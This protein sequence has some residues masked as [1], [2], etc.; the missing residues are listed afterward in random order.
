MLFRSVV[1]AGVATIE[2]QTDPWLRE[3]NGMLET[4]RSR[5]PGLSDDLAPVRDL[6]GRPRSYE[7]GIGWAYDAFSPIYSRRHNPNAIDQEILRHGW[8]I[9]MPPRTQSFG[10]AA[11]DL[12]RFPGAYSRFL[13]LA[14]QEIKSPLSGKNMV[15]HLSDIITG[16]SAL[17]PVYNLRSSGPDGGKETFV[18]DQ[19]RDFQA[20]ARAQLLREIPALALEAQEK[21]RRKSELR[22][23]LQ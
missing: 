4:L 9:P 19:M 17:S 22:L 3:A 2:R 10:G 15:D 7:S 16:K 21:Q 20:S 5:T 14:G 8:D 13:E 18:K 6:W 1:P 12:D 11:I 23:N